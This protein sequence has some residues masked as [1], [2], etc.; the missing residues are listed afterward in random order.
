MALAHVRVDVSEDPKAGKD[1]KRDLFF[2]ASDKKAP[3][4][5]ECEDLNFSHLVNY[6]LSKLSKQ[7]R[8][9]KISKHFTSHIIFR[10]TVTLQT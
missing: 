3:Q 7:M 10:F 8:N 2:E 1:Q 5:N 4:W 6:G 9:S